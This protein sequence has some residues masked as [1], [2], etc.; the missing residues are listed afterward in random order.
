MAGKRWP[1][2]L[3]KELYPIGCRLY[4][5]GDNM[6]DKNTHCS[7]HG[8]LAR[9]NV[10]ATHTCGDSPATHTCWDSPATHTYGDSSGDSSATHTCGDS[11]A[12][13][14]CGES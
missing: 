2:A 4:P 7:P 13:H 14:T 11:P 9:T 3:S 6:I 8:Y 10:D 12:T 5:I 1:F